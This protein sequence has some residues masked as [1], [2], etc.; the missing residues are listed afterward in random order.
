[1]AKCS[2]LSSISL[3]SIKVAIH[4]CCCCCCLLCPTKRILACVVHCCSQVFICVVG[5]I[6]VNVL[7]FWSFEAKCQCKCSNLVVV[8]LLKCNNHLNH[9]QVLKRSHAGSLKDIKCSPHDQMSI[10]IQVLESSHV[11]PGNKMPLCFLLSA[12]RWLHVDTHCHRHSQYCHHPHYWIWN[13]HHPRSFPRWGG[14][15][16]AGTLLLYAQVLSLSLS[17]SC[18]LCIGHRALLLTH[19]S[20]SR[21]FA[22]KTI[23]GIAFTGYFKTEVYLFPRP[24]SNSVCVFF[25][26]TFTFCLMHFY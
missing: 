17:I 16:Y 22:T 7:S 14:G 5:V 8:D 1:M 9:H 2:Y 3:Q 12:A 13:S 24:I 10:R 11:W 20:L 4:V 18:S 26:L 25:Y 23:F 6:A 21:S 15:I 19:F